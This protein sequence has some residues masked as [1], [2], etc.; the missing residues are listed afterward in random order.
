MDW[1]KAIDWGKRKKE[2]FVVL[3]LAKGKK[4]SFW[5]WKAP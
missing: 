5:K 2:G 3:S 1:K 4:L